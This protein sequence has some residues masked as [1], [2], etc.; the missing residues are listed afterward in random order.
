MGRVPQTLD[1]FVAEPAREA[2]VALRP[3]QLE[4]ELWIAVDLPALALE[5]LPGEHFA[6]PAVVVEAGKR[7]EVVACNERAHEAGV[8]LGMP[9]GTAMA[10]VARLTV[11]ERD[12]RL[13]QA[14][15]ERLAAWAVALT[16]LVSIAP[17][18]SV[19]LEVSGSLNLFGGLAAIR[20]R[21]VSELACRHRTY[22]VSAAPTPTAA[23]WLAR[24]GA[25]DIASW[26]EGVSR[27]G[28]LPL[29]ATRWPKAVQALLGDLGVRSV[30]DCARLP[31]EGLARRIGRGYLQE[32]DR[33]YGRHFDLR[34]EFKAPDHW[35]ARLELPEESV[36]SALLMVAIEQLVDDLAAELRHRQAQ[37]DRLRI[38]Y[39]HYRHAPTVESFDLLEPVHEPERLLRLVGDRIERR[40][41]PVPVVALKVSSGVFVP[42]RIRAAGLFERKPAEERAGELLE[43]LQA[44]FG[45][46]AV[47]GLCT[48]AEHRPEKAWGKLASVRFERES[49]REGARA[50][51]ARPLW[52]LREPVLLTALRG[53]ER[54][55][56]SFELCSGPERI[57]SGWW[58]GQD[59]ARDYYAAKNSRGQ[60]LWVF[61]DQLSSSWYLH[62][63]FG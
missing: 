63:L 32:L 59:I 57:E 28:A 4:R 31:R 62:G 15:L 16:P 36:D 41:L 8:G 40:A 47:Y 37:V 56:G 22:R 38:V 48:V 49:A 25:G 50:D 44:R 29:A 53:R 21:L 1:L 10:L 42:M 7:R 14:S 54:E 23:V 30:G 12:P 34:P 33:A 58:D 5:C 20:E 27:L 17:P 60:R 39:E 3:A 19:L 24:A 61:R 35:S 46:G 2:P 26:Q 13:E 45:A 43:R 11:L 9:L 18:E 55:R 52:L 6:E 51:C